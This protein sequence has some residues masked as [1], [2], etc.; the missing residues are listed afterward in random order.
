M[1]EK[2]ISIAIDGPAGAGKS[3]IAKLLAKSVGCIYV[4]TG[5]LY[6]TVALSV[7]EN[8]INP[9]DSEA[10][11]EHLNKISV[12]IAYKDNKQIVLLNGNDVSEKIRTPMVSESASVT[13]AIPEVRAFLLELQRKLA[14]E[15]S[16]VMDGRDI[17]T[18]VLP[19]ADVKIFLTASAEERATRRY[20]E[21]IEK[22]EQ[23]IYEEV[24][25]DIVARDERDSNRAVAP[26]KCA[27]D[28]TLV[29]STGKSI[30]EVISEM[31]EIV[32]LKTK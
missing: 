10:V 13:S 3:T 7:L 22:G 29:D 18:V 5:A 30:E 21:L 25:R 15:H 28:A 8:G 2:I 32:N 27:D 9:T 16:V 12:D 24:L 1:N 19:N 26:L 14:R 31:Q 11:I 23:V 20:K 17:A 6:R 4:D